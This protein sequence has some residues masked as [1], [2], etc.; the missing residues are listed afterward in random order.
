MICGI[1]AR[2]LVNTQ[3]RCLLSDKEMGNIFKHIIC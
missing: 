3:S 1:D 2:S